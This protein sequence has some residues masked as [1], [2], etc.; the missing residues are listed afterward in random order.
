MLRLI[1][2]IMTF[3][4]PG[5]INLGLYGQ[6]NHIGYGPPYVTVCGGYGIW[7]YRRK[8][9]LVNAIQTRQFVSNMTTDELREVVNISAQAVEPCT[10][11]AALA[12]PVMMPWRLIKLLCVAREYCCKT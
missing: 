7:G 9:S 12:A 10:D 11:A 5:E 2:W 8:G 6:F 4:L 3:D 1:G